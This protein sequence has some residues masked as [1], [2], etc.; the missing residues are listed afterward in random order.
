[1]YQRKGVE[2]VSTDRYDLTLLDVQKSPAA[3][4]LRYI[5]VARYDED[6]HSVPHS[7]GCAEIFH[8]L[9]GNGQFLLDSKSVPIGAGDL[10]F[11]DPLVRHT[12]I[13]MGDAPLEY[14]VLGIEGIE[15][16]NSPENDGGC[17]ILRQQEYSEEVRSCLQN[18]RRELEQKAPD[19]EV[20]CGHLAELLSIRLRRSRAFSATVSEPEKNAS[21]EGALARRYMERHF[22]EPINLE[23]LARVAHI[24]KYHLSHIFQREYGVSPIS[25]L[26]SLRIRESQRLLRSTDHSVAQIAQLTGFSSPSYFSQSF[27]K[28]VGMTPAQYRNQPEMA[29]S[30]AK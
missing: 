19:F 6:W 20:A 25:Y 10:V 29:E 21:K 24:N 7:H 11:V 27:H 5:S 14:M 15:L 30:T 22:K 28:A 26:L 2:P 16:A 4:S 13:S 23:V 1:M 18:L 3:F 8:V 17:L 12:E 9:R